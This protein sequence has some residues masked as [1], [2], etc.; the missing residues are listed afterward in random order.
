[1]EKKRV[2]VYLQS[3]YPYEDANTVVTMP[4][5]EELL[6]HFNVDLVACDRADKMSLCSEHM[7]CRGGG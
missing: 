4:L 7:C 3:F 5:I 6:K 2:L 1:M